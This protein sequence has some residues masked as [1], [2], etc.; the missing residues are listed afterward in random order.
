MIF[1]IHAA[2]IFTIHAA[3]SFVFVTHIFLSE[4]LFSY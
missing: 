4:F 2:N 3:V 1:T